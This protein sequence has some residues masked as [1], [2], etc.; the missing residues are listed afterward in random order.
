[1]LIAR[2]WIDGDWVDSATRLDSVDP[3]TGTVIGT[4]A[5]GGETEALLAIAA[6]RRAFVETGWRDDRRLRAKALNEMADRFEART[7]ELVDL[8]IGPAEELDQ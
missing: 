3:A 2:H 4:Y 7:A 6:A 8:V 5:D 1:M